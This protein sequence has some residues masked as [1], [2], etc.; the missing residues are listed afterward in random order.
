MKELLENWQKFLEEDETDL[1]TEVAPQP[2]TGRGP[3]D[4]Q[5][6]RQ[7]KQDAESLT[8]RK[9]SALSNWQANKQDYVSPKQARINKQNRDYSQTGPD[10]PEYAKKYQQKRNTGM[11]AG[12]DTGFLSKLTPNIPEIGS[13][14][15]A[16]DQKSYTKRQA[17]IKTRDDKR[18]KSAEAA[19]ARAGAQ[20]QRRADKE[21]AVTAR[22]RDYGSDSMWGSSAI[23]QMVRQQADKSSTK[24]KTN[25]A[26]ALEALPGEKRS[27]FR[28]ESGE[29]RFSDKQMDWMKQNPNLVRQNMIT[30]HATGKPGD[31]GY[32]PEQRTALASKN[33]GSHAPLADQGSRWARAGRAINPFD[34][35]SKDAR[36]YKG[37]QQVSQNQ[38]AR[39]QAARAQGLTPAEMVRG[40]TNR[41]NW[42]KNWKARSQMPGPTAQPAPTRPPAPTP[43]QNPAAIP[44]Q[45]AGSGIVPGSARALPVVNPKQTAQQ[46][47]GGESFAPGTTETQK[48]LL[49]RS[50]GVKPPPHRDDEL[51]E[52]KSFLNKWEQF[53]ARDLVQE[54]IEPSDVDVSSF[55]INQTLEPNVWEGDQNLN[56]TVRRR[57]LHLV[58]KFWQSLDLPDL[59]IEDITFTGSLANHNWS[60]FSD[61]DLHILVDFTNL[62]GIDEITE[63]LMTAKRVDWN[64]KHNIEI[65]GFEVEIYIQDS[66]EVHHSTGVYSVLHDQWEVKP[67]YEDFTIDYDNVK[68]KAAH[69]MN[70]I[71]KIEREFNNENYEESISDVERLKEKLRK[72]RK[73][74]L[75]QGG[76]YS[77]ENLAFKALRRNGYLEKLSRFKID[78]YDKIMSL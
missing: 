10:A 22:D 58:D 31:K 8:S 63:A 67:Q 7:D 24:D 66:N 35:Q 53:A 45:H 39:Q 19:N 78:S 50:A 62:P 38:L 64:N 18:R 32:E 73:C 2:G 43:A 61:V 15:R 49:R 25:K 21:T 17:K 75:E 5:Q 77:P 20:T 57:L 34:Q 47:G 3:A 29:S 55:K 28:P 72:F 33:P 12:E 37:V 69:I 59:R 65:F 46:Q 42:D 70:Q 56:P 9:A 41:Q 36:M 1:L 6:F 14:P 27:A 54:E 48:D 30:T 11:F 44:P 51:Q 26:K 13:G 40:T 16:R 71:D 23:G 76:E 4:R 74:G 60:Q 52:I 68:I